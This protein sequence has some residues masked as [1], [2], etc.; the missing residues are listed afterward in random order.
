MRGPFSPDNLS[1]NHL[2]NPS[3]VYVRG[4]LDCLLFDVFQQTD[5]VSDT[6]KVAKALLAV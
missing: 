3:P 4:L 5:Q 2:P 1:N 6:H